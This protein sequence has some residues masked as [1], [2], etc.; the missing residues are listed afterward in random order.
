M[1]E[2]SDL[3]FPLERERG[4]AGLLCGRSPLSDLFS[5]GF[6]FICLCAGLACS[7]RPW[8]AAR[9]SA[10]GAASGLLPEGEFSLAREL[11][12][13]SSVVLVQRR[14]VILRPF[15]SIV[16]PA[17]GFW[18]ACG[19]LPDCGVCTLKFSR[20]LGGVCITRPLGFT[21]TEELD[22]SRALFILSALLGIEGIWGFV[23]LVR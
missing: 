23:I 7:D 11:S 5:E 8:G 19:S 17:D 13:L 9:R 18:S 2:L 20:S 14:V 16:P 12:P 4:S 21:P 22:S 10:G 6:R 15:C 3:E 1:A